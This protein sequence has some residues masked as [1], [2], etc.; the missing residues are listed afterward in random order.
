[1]STRMIANTYSR[2]RMERLMAADRVACCDL[3]LS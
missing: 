3:T 2:E 1:V